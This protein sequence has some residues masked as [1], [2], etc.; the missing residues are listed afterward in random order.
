M[1]VCCSKRDFSCLG[2]R[3]TIKD[4]VVRLVDG[5]NPYQG[6]NMTVRCEEDFVDYEQVFG[7]CSWQFPARSEM[8]SCS[9]SAELA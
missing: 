6:G 9:V 2:K 3:T 4:P 7:T 8:E 5:E 1:M